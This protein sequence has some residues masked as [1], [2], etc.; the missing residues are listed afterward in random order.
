M[1]LLD[2]A[3]FLLIGGFGIRGLISGF[4]TESLS[5]AAVIGGVIAVRFLHA[6]ATAFLT[7]HMGSEYAAA[8]LAFVAV[9]AMVFIG[10]KML[11]GMI[12]RQTKQSTLGMVDRMLGLGFGAV[13]GLLIA[14]L[15]FVL[16]TI[17]HDSL[18]GELSPRPDFM[19]LSRSYPLLNASGQA[20]SAWIAE[21]S[22]SGGLLGAMGVEG[23]DMANE[24]APAEIDEE[25]EE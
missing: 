15:G 18:Y 19:R 13:K 14:T 5:L 7:P 21:N 24:T 10:G 9:F 4:V 3:V 16:F 11:A 17:V 25:T 1:A 22:R 6:P 20:M 12:G 2:I 8:L 23:D